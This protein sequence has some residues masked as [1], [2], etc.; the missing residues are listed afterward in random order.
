M[1][2]KTGYSL[3]FFALLSLS[4]CAS[5]PPI[6]S[7]TD[8]VNAN[9]SLKITAPEYKPFVV[10]GLLSVECQKDVCTM[11]EDDFRTNQNDKWNLLQ[12]HKL[13]HLKDVIR[14]KAYNTLVD[15]RVHNEMALIKREAA[16]NRLEV[17]LQKERTYNTL[18]TWAER[19]L[20][21]TGFIVFG[22]L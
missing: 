15:A 3:I 17:T 4:A 5:D 8:I 14:V 19:L 11:T 6:P 13:N 1:Q 16:I 21:I 20:F 18:K 7:L 9:D 22:I 12:V 10:T 2:K